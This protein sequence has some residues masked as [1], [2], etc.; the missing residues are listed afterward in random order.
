[1][2]PSNDVDFSKATPAVGIANVEA[3]QS[4]RGTA[5]RGIDFDV[6]SHVVEIA[7]DAY[8]GGGLGGEN[9]IFSMSFTTSFSGVR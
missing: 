5:S 1:M 2:T 6:G 9:L 7:C 4:R 8:A 3:E